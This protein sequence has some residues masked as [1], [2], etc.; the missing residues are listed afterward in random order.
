MDIKSKNSAFFKNLST[1]LFMISADFF[2]VYLGLLVVIFMYIIGGLDRVSHFDDP[3]YPGGYDNTYSI[4]LWISIILILIPI[5]SFIGS[6]LLAREMSK[7]SLHWQYGI[8]LITSSGIIAVSFLCYILSIYHF[9]IFQGYSFYGALFCMIGFLVL[10]ASVAFFFRYYRTLEEV[11]SNAV[12]ILYGIGLWGILDLVLFCL[13]L[14]VQEITNTDISGS[15]EDLTWKSG[16]Y[17]MVW[18]I[19]SALFI[20]YLLLLL[21]AVG[22]LILTFSERY[23]NLPN[24]ETNIK[25]VY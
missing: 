13:I 1:P 17:V 14:L 18:G 5:I 23:R 10:A 9:S 12:T 3:A 19:L 4:N 25:I 2:F 20:I 15:L 21:P 16:S 11:S 24:D 7:K 8:P 22:I 6:I